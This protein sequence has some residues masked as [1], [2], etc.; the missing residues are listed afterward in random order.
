MK[1]MGLCGN[2]FVNE[3]IFQFESD[4][5]AIKFYENYEADCYRLEPT[6]EENTYQLVLVYDAKEGA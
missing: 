1:Y 4:Q 3:R 5:E 2:A 6:D